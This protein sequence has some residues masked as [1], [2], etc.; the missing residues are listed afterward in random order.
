M[1]LTGGVYIRLKRQGQGL[2]SQLRKV[3][4]VEMQVKPPKFWYSL[5]LPCWGCW[6][7]S[8]FCAP[9]LLQLLFSCVG[10]CSDMLPFIAWYQCR[11]PFAKT[12]PRIWPQ[13]KRCHN[14]SIGMSLKFGPVWGTSQFLKQKMDRILDAWKN[15][16]YRSINLF[17]VL[18]TLEPPAYQHPIAGCPKAAGLESSRALECRSLVWNSYFYVG[19]SVCFNCLLNDFSC[20]RILS[21]CDW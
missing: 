1:V 18:G 2:R 5:G 19:L 14:D 11:L 9:Y 7:L 6:V 13:A 20:L 8:L 10:G 15:I 12:V 3:V 16:L 21:P 4:K 17:V